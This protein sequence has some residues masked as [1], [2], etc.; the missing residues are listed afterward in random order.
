MPQY[1]YTQFTYSPALSLLFIR[2]VRRAE[3]VKFLDLCNHFKV[4]NCDKCYLERFE[5]WCCRRMEKISWT[6]RVR[7][8]EELIVK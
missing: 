2:R 1:K 5:M 7:N 8:E 6:D 3:V 4:K